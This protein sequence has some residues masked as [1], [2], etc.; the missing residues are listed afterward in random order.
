MSDAGSAHVT[1]EVVLEEGCIAGTVHEPDGREAPFAGWMGLISA[2]ERC[3]AG[4]HDPTEG[5]RT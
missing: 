3:R 1:V 2:L 5:E 4:R